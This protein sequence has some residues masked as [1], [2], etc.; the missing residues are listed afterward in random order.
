MPDTIDPSGALHLDARVIPVPSSISADAQTFLATPY[1]DFKQP[2]VSDVAGW[3]KMI[4]AFNRSFDAVSEHVLATMP[5]TVER[6][7]IAGVTVYVGTPQRLRHPRWAHL[8][9]HGGGWVLLGGKYAMAEAALIAT[10]FGCTAFSV[11]YRMPPEHPFPAA[12]EDALSVYR[13][14][15]SQYDPKRVAIS[16]A[17]AGGNLTA[18]ATLKLRDCGLP[19]PGAVG[20]LTPVTDLTQASDTLRTHAGIDTVLKAP[21][22]GMIALYASGHELTDPYLSPIFGDFSRGFPPAFLQSGTRD[23]LLSDTVRLHRKLVAAGIDAE[24]H[25]WEAM[26]HGG[27]GGTAPED[28]ELRQQ[29]VQFVEQRLR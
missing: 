29:L 10:Q 1:P 8:T 22:D 25:V 24:L 3:K 20:L 9:L 28:R 4:A 6:R 26:P 2:P 13:E 21:L 7:T 16:G 19:L 15:I 27:F 11:D 14:I 17:S 18:A 5:A 12:V 23:V